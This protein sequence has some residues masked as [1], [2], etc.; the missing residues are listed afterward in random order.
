MIYPEITT[1]NVDLNQE[2]K[3]NIS[4]FLIEDNHFHSSFTKYQNKLNI[5]KKHY[6]P[7][8]IYESLFEI[9]ISLYG[10]TI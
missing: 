1:V 10:V 2:S 4:P 7:G 6:F 9:I 5:K 8:K 3:Y